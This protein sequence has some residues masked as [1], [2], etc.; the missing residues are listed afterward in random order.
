MNSFPVIS[1]AAIQKVFDEI[2]NLYAGDKLKIIEG[3]SRATTGEL[4]PIIVNQG[5]VDP[6]I[7]LLRTRLSR[8]ADNYGRGLLVRL[9][10]EL[11]SDLSAT[12]AIGVSIGDFFS[13]TE[14]KTSDSSS[15]KFNPDGTWS[16]NWV[17]KV[18]DDPHEVALGLRSK[19]QNPSDIVPS[20]ILEYVQ[21]AF[22]AYN[23]NHSGVA[24]SLITIALEGTLRDALHS[25][26]ITYTPF[27]PREDV[28]R[29][30][31]MQ[32]HKNPNGF[33][34][35]F[36]NPKPFDHN[37]FLSN[38]GDPTFKQVRIKR[39]VKN[40]S[41]ALEMRDCTDL[42]DYWSASVIEHNAV[43]QVSGLGAALDIGRNHENIIQPIDLPPDLDRMIQTVRNN[44][45]HLSGA[46]MAME[47]QPGIS[48]GDFLRNKNRVFDSVCTIGDTIGVIYKK[49]A[50][51]TL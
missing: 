44:L 42:L 13:K 10:E 15:I 4:N 30:E 18:G 16:W 25:R 8:T 9:V 6:Q 7:D 19:N 20:Y 28:Y 38:P 24:L 50:S 21:Q 35:T 27:A 23:Q 49:L 33:L 46:A 48:L 34:V 1:T 14:I 2:R 45:I 22:I 29:L 43:R 47:V 39:V 41:F 32:I 5:Q 31:E 12:G 11:H 26:G 40:G 37:H 36:P 3:A 17:L 51:G